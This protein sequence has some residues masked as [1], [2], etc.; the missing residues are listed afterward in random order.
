MYTTHNTNLIEIVTNPHA[1][2]NTPAVLQSS[3][4]ELKAA[5]GDPITPE[6]MARLHPNYGIIAE[7]S[8]VEAPARPP[9]ESAH[10]PERMART[11]KAVRKIAISR[12]YPTRGYDPFS[13]TGGNAA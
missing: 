2:Q 10:S 4:A 12:G 8:P 7:R 6:R 9:H 5:R 1:H 13:P 11:E 3:W